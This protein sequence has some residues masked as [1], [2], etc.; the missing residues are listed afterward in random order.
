M[1]GF[2]RKLFA[3]VAAGEVGVQVHALAFYVEAEADVGAGAGRVAAVL[4]LHDVVLHVRHE[5][6]QAEIIL[7][8]GRI[9]GE[10]RL[11]RFFPLVKVK[12]CAKE[13][14]FFIE[15]RSYFVVQK[16]IVV[17]IMLVKREVV[18][19][20]IHAAVL[21][22]QASAAVGDEENVKVVALLFYEIL[23]YVEHLRI[24]VHDDIFGL[25]VEVR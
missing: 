9:L 23:V 14:R 18:D 6:R 21:Q 22:R 11:H 24:F 17:E 10:E 19:V 3:V 4:I 16:A 20:Q 8:A 2:Q 12:V 5:K 25:W 15:K 13:L 7:R 1:R